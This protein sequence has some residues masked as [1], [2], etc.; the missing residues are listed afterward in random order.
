MNYHLPLSTQSLGVH[1]S[2]VVSFLVVV[3]VDRVLFA[4]VCCVVVAIRRGEVR[5]VVRPNECT[6][7]AMGNLRLRW[8]RG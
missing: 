6:D 8:D 5:L 1:Y 4:V 2:Y 3:V 7:V